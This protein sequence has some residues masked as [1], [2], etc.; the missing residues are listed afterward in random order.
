M[1]LDHVYLEIKSAA[2]HISSTLRERFYLSLISLARSC[3]VLLVA[4]SFADETTYHSYVFERCCQQ[5]NHQTK[6]LTTACTC[7]RAIPLIPIVMNGITCEKT[8]LSFQDVT[9]TYSKGTS[10]SRSSV[11]STKCN[12]L[13]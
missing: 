12:H 3:C 1:Y 9:L 13:Y 8:F 11:G 6:R 7:V 10:P 5:R 4:P 2:S